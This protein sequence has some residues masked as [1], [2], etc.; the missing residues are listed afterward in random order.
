M[1]WKQEESAPSRVW[2]EEELAKKETHWV[3][4]YN[5]PEKWI[6]DFKECYYALIGTYEVDANLT[7][8]RFQLDETKRN[9]LAPGASRFHTV[10][11]DKRIKSAKLGNTFT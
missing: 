7:L 2:T 3:C 8:Y 6:K 1:G 9:L 4:S 5:D 10:L 11:I